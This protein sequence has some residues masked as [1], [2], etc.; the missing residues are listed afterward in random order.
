MSDWEE[1]HVEDKLHHFSSDT[2]TIRFSRSRCIHAGECIRGLPP[3]FDNSRLRWI[4]PAQAS[5]DE[6]S[7]V[8]RRCPTG[9]LHFERI[10][11]GEQETP[12]PVN[13]AVVS[14]DGPLYLRGDLRILAEDGTEILR[15]TRVALCRCGVSGRKPLCDGSHDQA[16]FR[17]PGL[18]EGPGSGLSSAHAPLVVTVLVGGALRVEGP[19]EIRAADG[20]V[21]RTSGASFCRC[22]SSARKPF[23]DGSHGRI[24]FEVR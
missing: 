7:S 5:P 23:C 21:V 8:V 14:P 16:G 20:S 13:L 2:I 1:E 19:L 3:V 12:D 17:D 18:V 10:D 15:D 11:E 6:I 24:G 9:A 22:G 4:D